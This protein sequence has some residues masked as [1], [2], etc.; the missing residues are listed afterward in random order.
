MLEEIC[1]KKD[2]AIMSL[3]QEIFELEGRVIVMS[4]GHLPHLSSPFIIILLTED[5]PLKCSYVSEPLY[6][7]NFLP[8]HWLL[9]KR[10]SQF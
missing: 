8:Q 3:K 5:M 2:S 6:S 10:P 4:H 1:R 9:V 7:N